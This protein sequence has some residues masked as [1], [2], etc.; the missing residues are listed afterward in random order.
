MLKI[1]INS[2]TSF[3]VHNE[4]GIIIIESNENPLQPGYYYIDGV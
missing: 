2:K 4:Q 1:I 3:S